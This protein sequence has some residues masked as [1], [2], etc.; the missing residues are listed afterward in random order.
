MAGG[1][2]ATTLAINLD[3]E[4]A[5]RHDQQTVLAELHGQLGVLV[6]YLD[7]DAK[8]T[9][10]DLVAYHSELDVGLVEQA[11]TPVTPASPSWRDRAS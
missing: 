11:L 3:C 5:Q 1:C 7:V 10:D 6:T 2:G 8:Y 4:L 9:L